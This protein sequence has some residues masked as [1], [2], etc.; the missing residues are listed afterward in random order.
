MVRAGL[1]RQAALRSQD[2]AAMNGCP[3]PQCI[4]GVPSQGSENNGKGKCRAGG[5]LRGPPLLRELVGRAKAS[6]ISGIS[7]C[8]YSLAGWLAGNW[9][10]GEVAAR[11][12]EIIHHSIDVGEFVIVSIYVSVFVCL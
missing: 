9:G 7:S 10:Q 5:S 12:T 1:L 11:D 4:V 6:N 8:L 3:G 2:E